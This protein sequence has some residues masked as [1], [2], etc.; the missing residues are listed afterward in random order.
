MVEKKQKY[1]KNIKILNYNF[2]FS[3][4]RERLARAIFLG[5][6]TKSISRARRSR[7]QGDAKNRLSFIYK[8]QTNKGVREFTVA[9][10]SN[11]FI[12]SFIPK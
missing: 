8:M 12:V 4:W 6:E 7:Q 2:Y 11:G 1:E 9:T 3:C 5:L 10:G